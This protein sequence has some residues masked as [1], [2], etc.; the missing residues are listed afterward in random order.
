MI[1]LSAVGQAPQDRDC[2]SDTCCA[3]GELRGARWRKMRD[4]VTVSEEHKLVTGRG[5]G[6]SKNMGKLGAG[7][8]TKGF[9]RRIEEM[10]C[11]EVRGSGVRERTK[12]NKGLVVASEICVGCCK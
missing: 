8:S 5:G 2:E 1:L 4:S 3:S 12:R 11:A 6:D 7:S 10:G 9:A